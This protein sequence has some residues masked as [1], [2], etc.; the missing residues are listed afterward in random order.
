MNRYNPVAFSRFQIV[1]NDN[2]YDF[3]NVFESLLTALYNVLVHAFTN[4]GRA[5]TNFEAL[6]KMS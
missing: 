5:F 3:I 2:S 4:I 6:P 1:W